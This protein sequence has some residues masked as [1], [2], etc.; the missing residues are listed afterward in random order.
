MMSIYT[1]TGILFSLRYLAREHTCILLHI[2]FGCSYLSGRVCSIPFD[3][4]S[5]HSDWRI[6]RT[7]SQILCVFKHFLTTVTFKP[8]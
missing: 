2:S 7:F 4:K 3:R 1:C 5:E 8:F 6:P